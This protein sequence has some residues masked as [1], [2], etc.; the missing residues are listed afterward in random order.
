VILKMPEDSILPLG[1]AIALTALF[2][3]ALLHLWWLAGAAALVAALL[4][5]IWLWPRDRLAQTVDMTP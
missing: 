4:T 5:L 2:A 1:C 3:A